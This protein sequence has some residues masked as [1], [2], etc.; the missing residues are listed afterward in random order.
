[1]KISN[2]K[3]KKHTKEVKELCRQAALNQFKNGM[4]EA[5][6]QKYREE[7]VRNSLSCE[8]LRIPTY[9]GE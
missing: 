5:T 9:I 6:K 4:P 1:M 7:Q 8:F 3:D 2:F